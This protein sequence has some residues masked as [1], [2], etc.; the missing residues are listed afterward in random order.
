MLKGSQVR[1]TMIWDQFQWG[2]PLEAS[3]FKPEIPADYEVVD[4]DGKA[5]DSTPKTTSAEA[6]AQQ[7]QAEPF[8]GDFDASAAAGRERLDPC[9]ALTRAAPKPQVRLL[10]SDEIRLSQDACVA[11]WPPYEQVQAQL[12]QELQAK[13]SIDTKDVNGLVTTANRFTQ[14]VLGTGWEPVRRGVSIHLCSP[15]GGR[16]RP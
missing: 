6:F 9:S 16:D 12:R 15:A 2:V 7:T 11:K 4:D 5:P 1:K 13:L 14:P 3:L 8:L 10:G